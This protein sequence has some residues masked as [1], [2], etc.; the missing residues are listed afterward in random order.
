MLYV[1][2]LFT[3][4]TIA[5]AAFLAAPRQA[6]G[7]LVFDAEPD[8]PQPFGY[9]MA[10]IAVRTRDTGA[11][12]ASLGLAEPVVA[13]WRTGLGA[14]Y[15]P[16]LGDTRIFVSPPVNGWTLVTGMS[17]P[18]PTGRRFVD[19][20]LPFLTELGDRFVEV[21]YFCSY[22]ELDFYAWAR[23]I[24]GK[25]LRA[26]AINDEGV[27]WNK[28]RPTKEEKAMGLKLFELRGVKGRKGDAGGEIL[29]Y[30]TEGHLMHLAGKWSLDPTRLSVAAASPANGVVGL[31]PAHWR[32]L[33]QAQAA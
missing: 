24:D 5:A 18:S 19:R 23:V 7:Q 27:V 29:L 21:Q 14:I 16:D 3:V 33:R 15:D 28:G 8:P 17:L 30:P 10:W 13:N 26:F 1:I 6:K 22:P 2:G 31:A 4:L 32:P 9:R 12:L 25:L 11:V 20:S